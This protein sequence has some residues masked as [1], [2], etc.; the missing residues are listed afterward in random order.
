MPREIDGEFQV[1]YA[2]AVKCVEYLSGS[3]Q[4]FNLF[5]GVCMSGKS[6]CGL[7]KGVAFNATDD[8]IARFKKMNWLQKK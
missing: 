6:E 5:W 7:H 8:E 4:R 2:G 1:I 3:Y